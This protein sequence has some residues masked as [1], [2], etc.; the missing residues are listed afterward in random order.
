MDTKNF[1][2]LTPKE[3]KK[4]A[5]LNWTSAPCGSNYSNKEFLSKEYFEEIE[6]YR[7]RTHPWIIKNISSFDIKDKNVLEIGFG[8]GTD[9]LSMARKGAI[10][11]GID[12]TTRNLEVT[13]KRLE[14]YGFNSKL[15]TGDAEHMP[16]EDNSMD[17]IYSFGVIHHS[18]D[19][20][21]I[22]SEI[23]RVLKPGGKCWIT[24]Y[25][26]NSVFF[27]WTVYLWNH[28]IKGGCKKYTLKQQLSLIEYPNNNLNIIVRLYKK[29][30]ISKLF[31]SFSLVKTNIEHLLVG[32]IA[33]LSKLI[34]DPERPRKLFNWLGK[35]WGWYVVVEAQ[36]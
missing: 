30:E 23:Y 29:D 12:L 24:V 9:H 14:L 11:H 20:E 6:A 4:Q 8:M 33:I 3:Y 21:K 27:W 1:C 28:I 2:D 5:Q 25:H 15:I 19:T 18:P 26:K 31:N 22:I 10:M 36:K 13:K 16:F 32:N 7:Y 35:R 34:S 17:F